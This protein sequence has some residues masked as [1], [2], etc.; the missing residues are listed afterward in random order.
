MS[1]NCYNCKQ[2][3][4]DADQPKNKH[5]ELQLRTKNFAPMVIGISEVKPKH[6]KYEIFINEYNLDEVNNY[7]MFTK[8]L[9]NSIGRGLI[10]YIRK[11]MLAKEVCFQTKFEECVFAEVKLNNNDKLLIGLF[12]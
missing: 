9:D 12:Y 4:K 10:L 1:E 7:D 8:N 5:F 3:Q 6:S 2:E 11:A